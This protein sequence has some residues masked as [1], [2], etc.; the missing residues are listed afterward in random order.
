MLGLC[1]ATTSCGDDGETGS[2]G[3]GGST[4]T[5]TDTGGAGGAGA[6]GGGGSDPGPQNTCECLAGF[7]VEGAAGTDCQSC[8]N[9]QVTVGECVELGQA[10]VAAGGDEDCRAIFECL[11][12]G[13]Y[14]P[15]IIEACIPKEDS[16]VPGHQ[17]FYQ[18]VDCVC[19]QCSES[20]VFEEQLECVPTANPLNCSCILAATEAGDCD[21]CITGA[22]A[23]GCAAQASACSGD[24]T[25]AAILTCVDGCTGANR[26]GEC[27]EACMGPV[28]ASRD[29][30][31]A[32]FTCS[33]G[34][35]STECNA[36]ATC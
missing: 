11:L 12:A 23:G 26:T 34:A 6:T 27:V 8:F 36:S 7:S 2:T 3:K 13:A 14:A 19:P 22:N 33:C 17:L 16:T 21:T 35:C 18:M 1:V 25:C 4:G 30:A 10:C 5:G 28:S 24:P 31:D 15:E 29:L 32:L 9:D 20:C